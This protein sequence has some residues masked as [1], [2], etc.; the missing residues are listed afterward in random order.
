M[1]EISMGNPPSKEMPTENTARRRS[2]PACV[3]KILQS[4]PS[5]LEIGRRRFDGGSTEVRRR[6]GLAC[7][8]EIRHRLHRARDRATELRSG[9]HGRDPSSPS[10]SWR[11]AVWKTIGLTTIGEKRG[12]GDRT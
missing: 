8:E 10:P 5:T 9:S 6:S 4:S 7:M 12:S 2:G 11:S 1:V 3:E